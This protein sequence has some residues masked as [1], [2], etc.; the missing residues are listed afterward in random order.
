MFSYFDFP[1]TSEP[2]AQALEDPVHGA[3]VA[4]L[5]QQVATLSNESLMLVDKLEKEEAK[6]AAL[7][8]EVR[9]L[10]DTIVAMESSS[11]PMCT[12]NECLL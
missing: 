11:L 4:S 3:A 6:S 2:Q 7:A 8:A 9:A 12:C 5:Q 10:K 1:E